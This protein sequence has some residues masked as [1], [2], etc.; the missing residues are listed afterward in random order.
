MFTFCTFGAKLQSLTF[1]ISCR[2]LNCFSCFH[3]VLI[4][5]LK[6]L[7]MFEDYLLKALLSN[8]PLIF[9]T[10]F[11]MLQ[12]SSFQWEEEF[13][14]YLNLNVSHCQ[15]RNESRQKKVT[16]KNTAGFSSYMNSFPVFLNYT[17]IPLVFTFNCVKCQPAIISN[18]I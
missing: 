4:R 17:D 13:G 9:F 18:Y 16:Q 3:M 12:G 1:D 11:V 14:E 5:M 6:R 8:D 7:S 15:K 10:F 2:R